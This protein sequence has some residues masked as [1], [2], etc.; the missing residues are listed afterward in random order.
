MQAGQSAL[1]RITAGLG[2]S[3]D[4]NGAAQFTAGYRATPG[5]QALGAGYFRTNLS[6]RKWP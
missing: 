4:P 2:L 1:Q 5:Y 3:N 6:L